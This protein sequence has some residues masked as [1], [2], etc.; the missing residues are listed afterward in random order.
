MSLRAMTSRTRRN[1]LGDKSVYPLFAIGAAAVGLSTY[2]TGRLF[3]QHP[4]IV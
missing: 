3:V 1:W 2:Y 4:D